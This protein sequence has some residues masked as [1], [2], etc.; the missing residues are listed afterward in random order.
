MILQALVSYYETLAARG[1]LPQPG[2]APVKVSYVLNLDDQGDI[3]TVVC[4]K[5]EVTRGKK[6]A[7]VPQTIQLPAPVK[8]TVG[9]TA[10]FLCDNSSY[11]LG[12]DKKGKPKRS[13]ECLQDPPRDFVGLGG[14]A[15]C[16]GAVVLFR[17]LAAGEI[18][19]TPGLCPPGYGGSFG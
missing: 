10:N 3:T 9:V 2:W 6:K 13:L 16:P 17:P 7:L 5:E 4:I 8:R 19:G 14:G 1:E 15:S 18:D 11:I 12:A